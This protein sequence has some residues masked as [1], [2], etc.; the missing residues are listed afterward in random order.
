MK[1]K[2]SPTACKRCSYLNAGHYV[3]G[4]CRTILLFIALLYFQPDSFG[5]NPAERIITLGSAITETAVSLGFGSHIVATDVTSEYPDFIKNVPKVSRNRSL[6]VEGLMRYQPT[7]ILAPQG[8]IPMAVLAQLKKTSIRVINIKQ[9]FTEKGALKFIMSVA[10][11]LN[12]RQQGITLAQDTQKRLSAIMQK[13]KADKHKP[14]KVLFIYARGAGNMTVAGKES[15]M[16]AIIRLAG[17]HNAVEEFTYFK[18]YSTEALIRAN[19]DVLL[20]FDF[21]T[22]SLGGQSAILRMPGVKL[23]A[24][25]KN[26]RIV[27]V[28]GALMINFSARLPEAI[29]DL[30]EKL[31][32]KQ[33]N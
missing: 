3:A 32:G 9:E 18:P 7:L 14:L 12:A 11:A 24:A 21:G 31:Y 30:Y 1:Q 6:S 13:I 22:K 8:D 29:A 33:G 28:D 16:D 5:T 15:N 25:G 26:K 4:F 20:L 23:T 2:Y 17:A 19:P 27:E 10:I